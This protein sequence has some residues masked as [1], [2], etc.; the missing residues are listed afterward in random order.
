LRAAA[1]VLCAAGLFAQGPY[2]YVGNI[3]PESALIAW[4]NTSGTGGRN[5]IGRQSISMGPAAV[6]IDNRTLPTTHNWMDVRGLKPDTTYPYEVVVNDRRIGGGEIRTNPL[7]ASRMTFFVIGDFGTGDAYQNRIAQAMWKEYAK[8]VG[9]ADPVRFVLTVGDNI[10]A[11]VNIA[12]LIVN[13]GDQDFDWD[14]KFYA[15]YRALLQ[16]IPFHPT[17]GNHDGNGSESRGDL[18]VYLDNFFFPGNRPAR[19]YTF[20][21]GGLADFFALDSTDN[22]FTGPPAPQYGRSSPQW[23]WLQRA[24]GEST[25]PWK[26]PYFHHPPFTAGPAHPSSFTALH[27]WMQLFERSGVKVVFSGHEHNLQFSEDND[28]TGHIRYIISGAGGQLREGNVTGKMAAAHIE[29]WAAHRHFL[30]VEIEG[31]TMRVTPVSY[32]PFAVQNR[33]HQVIS[34]PFVINLP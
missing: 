15:P 5:T 24:L 26:I 23:P 14:T 2:V 31:R 16:H 1:L 19:Y 10:Y 17:L 12:S 13:S 7:R 28:A 11:Y 6:R 27:H 34:M 21:Y 29:G 8:R 9:S 22:T 20:S 33:A 32:E 3:T 30:V 18:G 25:A 4:G